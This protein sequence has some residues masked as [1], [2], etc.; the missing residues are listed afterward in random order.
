MKVFHVFAVT[1]DNY[2]EEQVPRV[3]Y[4]DYYVVAASLPKALCLALIE[5][6]CRDA[7]EVW[8]SKGTEGA[9]IVVTPQTRLNAS[10]AFEQHAHWAR[11]QEGYVQAPNGHRTTLRALIDARFETYLQRKQLATAGA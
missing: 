10:D 3:R 6:N 2:A 5:P 4:H 7:S 9:H 1:L 8:C 11:I